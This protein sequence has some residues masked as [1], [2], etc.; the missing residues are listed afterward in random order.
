M[1]SGSFPIFVLSNHTTCC[2]IQTGATVPLIPIKYN[3]LAIGTFLLYYSYIMYMHNGDHKRKSLL[4]RD[5]KAALGPHSQSSE[6]S[7]TSVTRDVNKITDSSYSLGIRTFQ[8][9]RIRKNGSG[10]TTPA[11]II[12]AYS[13]YDYEY[14]VLKTISN[15]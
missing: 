14:D 15:S 7:R 13:M 8:R 6:P 9:K 3:H 11:L 5:T 12:T 10:S 2:Q 4:T 1:L